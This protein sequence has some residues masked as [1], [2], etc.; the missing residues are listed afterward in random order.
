[1][2]PCPRYLFIYTAVVLALFYGRFDREK[3][4]VAV[5]IYQ[6][7]DPVLHL[8]ID[9]ILYATAEYDY[10]RKMLAYP[11]VSTERLNTFLDNLLEPEAPLDIA[12]FDHLRTTSLSEENIAR[13]ARRG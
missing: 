2:F 12:L 6:K 3:S 8:R 13:A 7:I 1:V 5:R 10:N 9:V 4:A 11:H